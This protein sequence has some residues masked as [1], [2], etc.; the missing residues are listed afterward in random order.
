MWILSFIVGMFGFI[1][2]DIV[3]LIYGNEYLDAVPIFKVIIWSISLAYV[4]IGLGNILDAIGYQKLRFYF[5]LLSCIL[6][7][8]L[9]YFLIPIYGAFGAAIST[10]IA[11]IV[12]LVTF[13]ISVFK[14]THIVPFIKFENIKKLI[15]FLKCYIF[16]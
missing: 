13:S 11:R 9:N 8:V 1:F 7:I 4:T 14:I 10:L 12:I 6:N 3:V 15:D 16:P 2:S 5:V